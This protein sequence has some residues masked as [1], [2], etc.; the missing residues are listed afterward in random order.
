MMRV[1]RTQ[2]VTVLKTLLACSCRAV[3]FVVKK[4]GKLRNYKNKVV[5]LQPDFGMN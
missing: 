5:T 3:V 2:S 4:T 1:A